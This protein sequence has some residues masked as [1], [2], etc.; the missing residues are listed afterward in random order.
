[1]VG[2]RAFLRWIGRS[3]RR[4]AVTVVGMVLLVAGVIMLVT[5]GPGWLVIIAGLTVMRTEY[6]WARKALDAAKRRAIQAKDRVKRRRKR[7]RSTP[8][9]RP[10]GSRPFGSRPGEGPRRR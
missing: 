1:M 9:E 8:T 6:A 7:P 5:P 3:C 10:A 4:I 2:L